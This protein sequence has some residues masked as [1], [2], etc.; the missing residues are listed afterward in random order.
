MSDELM[1]PDDPTSGTGSN[2]EKDSEIII[3]EEVQEIMDTLPQV[4]REAVRAI[5][6]ALTIEKIWRGPLPPPEVLKKYNDAFPNG[7][8]RIFEWTERQTTHRMDLENQAIP[9]E[10]RQSRRGQFFGFFVAIAFGLISGFLIYTGHE[11]SGAV[12]GTVDLV[13]LVAVFIVG[14][15]RQRPGGE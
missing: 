14:R 8:E 12:L 6:T 15:N 7:A 5:V 13:A 10:L 11:I 1:P 9:E 3:P 4:Q 2:P